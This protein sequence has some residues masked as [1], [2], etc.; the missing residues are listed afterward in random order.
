MNFIRNGATTWIIVCMGVVGSLVF[1][2]GEICQWPA[3]SAN[4]AL[5]V[6][7]FF[8]IAVAVPLAARELVLFVGVLPGTAAVFVTWIPVALAE[9]ERPEFVIL[10]NGGGMLGH[11]GVAVQGKGPFKRPA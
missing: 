4:G 1:A 8:Y 7:S 2:V 9:A 6:V 5:I 3:L 11:L 10:V